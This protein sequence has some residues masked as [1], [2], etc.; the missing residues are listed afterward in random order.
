MWLNWVM[1]ALVAGAFVDWVRG[2]PVL[3]RRRVL[4]WS[5]IL[6]LLQSLGFVFLMAVSHGLIVPLVE[7]LSTDFVA[8]Y[9]AGGLAATKTPEAAYNETTLYEAEQDTTEPGIAYSHFR[10]PPIF[11][12]VCRL[13]AHLR[14][15]VAFVAFE[16]VTLGLYLLVIGRILSERGSLWLLPVLAFP[17]VFWT[18]GYGQNAFLTAAL[19]G[20]ATLF[21]DSRPITAGILFGALCYKPHFG[22]LV[23]VALLAG[24]RWSAF[25]AAAA[26]AAALAAVSVASSGWT[27]WQAY[28]TSILGSGAA[29]AEMA[30]FS[31]ITPAGAART[32]GLSVHQAY[33]VQ[34]AASLAAVALVQWTWW[35]ECSLQVR[36]A[37]LVAATLVV[38]PFAFIYDLMLASVAVAWLLCASRSIRFAEWEKWVL[39]SLYVLPLVA[40]HVGLT[41]HL[42]LIPLATGSLLVMCALRAW[43][44]RSF[45]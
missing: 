30:H 31:P 41:L 27:T 10:Y 40:L 4:A 35:R 17:A 8:F 34:A 13:L 19:F 37:T 1:A 24:R 15:L 33:I 12:L 45:A 39:A 16:G 11:L 26:C 25:G 23:P 42:P 21:I 38:I 29:D 9:A 3:A 32:V 22:I 28:F 7:P 2:A 44:E 5:G 18:L 6:L 43:R 36:S 20:A 14:Y